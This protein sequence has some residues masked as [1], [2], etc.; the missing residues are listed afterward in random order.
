MAL[1]KIKKNKSHR[2][3]KFHKIK[4]NMLILLVFF[5]NSI[6]IVTSRSGAKMCTQGHMLP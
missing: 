2:K 6:K 3:I 5:F 4:I 1:I